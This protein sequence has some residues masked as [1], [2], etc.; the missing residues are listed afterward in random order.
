MTEIGKGVPFAP[1]GD[2]A[3]EQRQIRSGGPTARISLICDPVEEGWT[4]MDLFGQRVLRHLQRGHSAEFEVEPI[5][6]GMARVLQRVPIMGRHRPAFNADRILHR[7]IRYP[8]LVGRLR[9]FDLHHIVDHSYS[10]LVHHLPPGRVVVTCHDLDAYRSVLEPEREERSRLFR[11]LAKRQ[12]DGLVKAAWIVTVSEVVRQEILG[13]GL[14]PPDRVVVIPNGV[15]PAMKPDPDPVFDRE[16]DR[17]LGPPGSHLDLIQVAGVFPRKRIDTALRVLAG[18]RAHHPT[19]RLIRVGGGLAPEHRRLAADLG[20][21]AA[22]VV[23]PYL[24][25]GVL[26]ALYRRASLALLPSEREGFGLPL[27]EAMACGT[28]VIASDID[29]FREVGGEEVSF[30]PVSDAGAWIATALR[31]LEER[32]RSD[33]ALEARCLAAIEASRRFT[34]ERHAEDLVEVYRSVL[35]IGPG[36][37]GDSRGRDPA[38]PGEH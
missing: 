10:Q 2:G 3:G 23:M 9:G 14:A 28:P 31:L 15:E 13:Y 36:M 7:F 34:W 5:R 17:L 22:V 1:A 25:S 33:P 8:Y 12:L 16:A 26:A 11:A 29:P 19:A 32:R 24:E 18:V 6:P 35:A 20:V 30:C 38:G 37:D 4:S 27:A 21:E